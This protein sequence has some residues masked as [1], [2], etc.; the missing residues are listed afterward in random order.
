MRVACLTSVFA[1][2]STA[3]LAD[4]VASGDLE[5]GGI[6]VIYQEG[7][8]EIFRAAGGGKVDVRGLEP[9]GYTYRYLLGYGLHLLEDVPT[10]NG[11]DVAGE[12]IRFEYGTGDAAMPVP[13]PG[14]DWRG[15]VN[16]IQTSGTSIETQVHIFGQIEILTVEDCIYEMFPVQSEYLENGSVFFREEIYFFPNLGFGATRQ[17]GRPGEVPDDYIIVEMNPLRAGSGS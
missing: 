5:A 13:S 10:Q 4:C 1:V 2:L 7:T 12:L 15:E 3:G 16:V 8:R 9:D 14:S 17:V 11:E 6:E